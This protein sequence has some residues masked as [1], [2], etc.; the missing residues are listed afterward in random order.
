MIC[1][2]ILFR[3]PLKFLYI[4]I[5]S[6]MLIVFSIIQGKKYSEGHDKRVLYLIALKFKV[7]IWQEKCKNNFIYH[8]PKIYTAK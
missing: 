7:L 6:W 3:M 8:R 1:K 5:L 2:N 4:S